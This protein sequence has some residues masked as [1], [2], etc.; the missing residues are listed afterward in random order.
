MTCD[1]TDGEWVR[2]LKR[3]PPDEVAL[4]CIWQDIY[5]FCFDQVDRYRLD[6]QFASEAAQ[7]ALR[8]LLRSLH[9]PEDRAGFAFRC[10]LRSFWRIIAAN[11]IKTLAV[12]EGKRQRRE[13]L[14]SG[15]GDMEIHGSQPPAEPLAGQSLILQ[16]LQPCLDQLPERQRS[17]FNLRYLTTNQ[18]GE[19]EEL[20]PSTVA[21]QFGISRDAINVAASY[22]RHALR[23][24]LEEHGYDS[25]ADML[26]L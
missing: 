1:Y 6:D 25:P 5:R 12:K 2:L 9:L 15:F 7:E 10:S 19:W 16:R 21:D 3:E 20:P 23:K 17:V 13:L 26:S 14:L 24:C 22:A 4:T 11:Y 8:R 18:A